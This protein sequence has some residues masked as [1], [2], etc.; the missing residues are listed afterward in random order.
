MAIYI[1][2]C[3]CLHVPP[4]IANHNETFTADVAYPSLGLCYNCKY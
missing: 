2:H 4:A 1:R 3:V